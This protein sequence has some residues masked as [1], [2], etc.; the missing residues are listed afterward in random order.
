MAMPRQNRQLKFAKAIGGIVVILMGLGVVA[1][2][3]A[4][5]QSGVISAGSVLALVGVLVAYLKYNE[6]PKK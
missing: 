4:A 2:G 3:V 5:G 1:M 6:K